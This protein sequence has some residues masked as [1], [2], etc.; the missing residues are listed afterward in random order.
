MKTGQVRRAGTFAKLV[1]T[2]VALGALAVPV[3]AQT[4]TSGGG[5]SS[6]STGGL[7]GGGLG[8]GSGT[9]TG[10]GRG[11]GGGGGTSGSGSIIFGSAGTGS[12]GSVTGQ[13]P[14]NKSNNL[15][16]Y[17]SSP[18]AAGLGSNFTLKSMTGVNLNGSSN[19]SGTTNQ[20]SAVLTAKGTF[21]VPL[22]AAVTSGTTTGTGGRG[23]A[24]GATGLGGGTSSTT[25]TGGFSTQGYRR[26]AQYV[27]VPD[28]RCSCRAAR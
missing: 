22:Y 4:T 20:A 11:T 9:G 18:M 19:T 27:T 5:F 21:G 16:P 17:Y 26:T 24:G 2:G 10:G 1:L 23:A 6:G 14:I 12:T 25:N 3:S 8:G 7:G 15:G 13:S 28:P